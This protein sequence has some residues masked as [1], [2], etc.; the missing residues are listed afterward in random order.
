LDREPGR[1]VRNRKQPSDYTRSKYMCRLS[2]RST[3]AG[4]LSHH[5]NTTLNWFRD[6]QKTV[7]S[8]TKN[9]VAHALNNVAPELWSEKWK[10]HSVLFFTIHD[11]WIIKKV[12]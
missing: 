1:E 5:I 11:F 12:L 7:R 10:K 3:V 9:E 4:G 8:V 6:C 2:V